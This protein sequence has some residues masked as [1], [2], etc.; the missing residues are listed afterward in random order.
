M[1][2]EL[3]YRRTVERLL[4]EIYEMHDWLRHDQMLD[5]KM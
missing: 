1:K 5:V 4:G 2:E 3:P